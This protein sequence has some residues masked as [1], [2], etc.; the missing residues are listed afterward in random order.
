MRKVVTL[1]AVAAVL[2]GV[3]ISASGCGKGKAAAKPGENISNATAAGADAPFDVRSV[4]QVEAPEVDP[5]VKELE[6]WFGGIALPDPDRKAFQEFCR[7]LAVRYR[8]DRAI[9]EG[10]MSE[11][12]VVAVTQPFIDQLATLGKPM[13]EVLIRLLSGRKRMEVE[14]RSESLCRE[15]PEVFGAIVLWTQKSR[16]AI[17]LCEEEAKNTNLENRRVFV[18]ALGRIGDPQ[19]LPFLRE[20]ALTDPDVDTKDEATAAIQAIEATQ[21]PKPAPEPAQPP[22]EKK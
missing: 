2:S 13:E 9:H 18:R 14:K 7:F 3:C 12:E 15:D 19:A 6:P 16:N 22:A 17:P 4:L 5:I 10:H 1:I 20:F 11:E 21:R 8:C